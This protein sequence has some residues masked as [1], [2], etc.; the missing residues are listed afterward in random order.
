MGCA[1]R[2]EDGHIGVSKLIME[3]DSKAVVET[4]LRGSASNPPVQFILGEILLLMRKPDW[5]VHI[6]H[7]QRS[8]NAWVDAS[9]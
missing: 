8:G 1:I 2:F 6:H 5:E 3:A 7:I 4:I 9:A